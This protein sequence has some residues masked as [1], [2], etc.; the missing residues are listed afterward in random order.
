MG[1]RGRLESRFRY[2]AQVVFN[3]FPFPDASPADLYDPLAMPTVLAR[4]HRDLDR[5][6]DRCYRRQPFT[7]E[8]NRTQFLFQRYETLV[9]PLLAAPR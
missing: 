5:A 1:R 7:T 4:A 3:N 6:V 8:L 9:A 2:S